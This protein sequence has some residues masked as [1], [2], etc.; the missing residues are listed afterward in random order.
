MRGGA[1]LL[2]QGQDLNVLDALRGELRLEFGE[3]SLDPLS[4]I[5]TLALLGVAI[6]HG[7]FRGGRDLVGKIDLPLR[8][9][10]DFAGSVEHERGFVGEILQLQRLVG[11]RIEVRRNRLEGIPARATNQR[12]T[13]AT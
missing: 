10:T 1:E 4:A 7:G 11:G 6:L 12:M 9:A 8:P 5:D 3:L 2:L 13:D